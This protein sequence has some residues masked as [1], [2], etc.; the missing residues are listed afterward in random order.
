M[1]VACITTPALLVDLDAMEFNLRRMADFFADK[2][3]KL[4]PHFKNHKAPLL[5]WK[6][7]RAGA[8]G[9][10][11]ATLREA[12]ILV[13]HGVDNVLIANEIAGDLKAERLAELSRQASVVVAVD[14]CSSIR[15]LARAQRNR[16]SQIQVVVDIDIGLLRCGVQPGEA[17]LKLA[18]CAA[19]EGLKVCGVM[20]Y[21]GH[22]QVMPPSP[23]R[24]QLVRAGSKSLVDS[25]AL[26]RGSRDRG[27]DRFHRGHWHLRGFRGPCR[28]HRHPGW[29]LSAHGY[30]IC[31]TRCALPPFSYGS[32]HRRQHPWRGACRDRLRREGN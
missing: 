12:E 15:D 16:G 9:M 29:F 20:G 7:L 32:D 19:G 28:H 21:D 18:E 22:F 27:F 10:T 24:D 13:H 30:D 2:P 4:R 5:A 31:R 3:C 17:A 8:I 6:Q 26:P 14:N 1:G 11:C 25:A 23:E